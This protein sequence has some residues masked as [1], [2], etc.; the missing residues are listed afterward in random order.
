[1][2]GLLLIGGFGTRMRPF[3]LTTPKAL[4]PVVNIPFI[5]Y[6]FQLLKKYNVDEII[7]GVG[8]KG[9]E[10][11]KI[12][13]IGKKMGLKVYLSYESKP[14]GTAG[15]KGLNLCL[16]VEAGFNVPKG[17]I[18]ATSAYNEYV[19]ANGLQSIIDENIAIIDDTVESLQTASE[20][21]RETFTQGKMPET[22]RKTIIEAYQRHELDKVAVRSSATAEDLPETSFAGQQDTFLNVEGKEALLRA[23]VDCWSSLWT[24]RAIGY[25]RRNKIPQDVVSLAVVVQAMVQSVTSGVLF[26]VNP[27]TGVRTEAV[28]NA[29][30]GLGEA[31]VSGRIEPDEYVV[32]KRS[33]LIKSVR[34]GEKDSSGRQGRYR[35]KRGAGRCPPG[36]PGPRN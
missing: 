1:M 16:L 27:L 20:H 9:E 17:F 18:I 34:L 11:K 36:R 13:D 5:K 32:D 10:F 2:K 30:F 23:V 24:P 7:L 28:V 8:Y 21:I 14:L 12:V 29:S 3:T 35:Q 31:L 6:Q 22:L 15:G 26:T 19:E 33:G 25:R 4:L